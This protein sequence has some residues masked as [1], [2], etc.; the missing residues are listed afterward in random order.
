MLPPLLL[1]LR[2]PLVLGLHLLLI[3]LAYYAAFALRFDLRMPEDVAPVFWST[4]PY[5]LGARLASFL[6]FGLFQGWWRHVG[7]RDLVDL[8]RAVTLSS[9]LLL[10]ALFMTSQVAGV[11]RSVLVLDWVLAVLIFGG[12]RFLVR[13]AR[14]RQFRPWRV[15]S[16]KRTLVV[17]AGAS[18]ERL[19]RHI[20]RDDSDSTWLVGLVDDDPG[21]RG[22]RMHG[23]PMLGTSED[24]PALIAARQIE[25]VIIA[26]PSATREEMRRIVQPCM[27][28]GVEFKIVPSM[29]EVLDGRARL[30]ELRKVQVEDLL[31]RETVALELEG[32]REDLEGRVVMVTGG[33]G[34]IGSELARQV[35]ALQPSRLVVLDQGETPLY[36]IAM[37]LETSFPGLD[38]VPVVADITNEGRMEAVFKKHR[39][40][41]VF[42]AAAYKHV[43]LME[44]NAVEAVRN[45]T[46]GTLC[47][48]KLAAK[49]GTRKFVLI[50]TDKAVHPSSV[51]GA[52][53]RLAERVVLGWP[54]L[55]A[56]RTDF[57]AVRF[58]NVLGSDG[59]VVPLFRKQLAA[60]KPLT[61]T[62]PDVTR[63]F[64]TIPEAVQLVLQAAALPDAAGRICMLDMG[65]P[66][67]IVELAENLIRLSGLEPYSDVPILFTGLRP[68]EKL[69]EELMSDVETTFPTA[70][71]KI[72]VV[73]TPE[74]EAEALVSGLDRLGAA[75]E[76]GSSDDCVAAICG[77]IPE[78]VSPLRERGLHAAF[79]R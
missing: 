3:P 23:I 14:E 33:A 2:R 44:D 22:M 36:Y 31:G 27:D 67:R 32:V 8:V 37:E 79:A 29:R 46:L 12:V 42:H 75:V 59:S 61:V 39:P 58:G 69:H 25:E 71:A 43:P 26:I 78:C 16:G 77:L 40:D 4:L 76:V 10:G 20:Q 15:R 6:I 51:M 19:L 56:S 68:G 47:V 21:K 1:R 35:A 45:N 38:I 30:S 7:M 41:S 73:Q 53:K 54:V 65:S 74:T 24:L 11:P 17:G 63:Y 57:R 5:L 9:A 55:Q 72:R 52:T 18:A 28:S 64:M 50:S 60:G 66:V 70:L 34:S 48:A 49:F 13:A 62:H